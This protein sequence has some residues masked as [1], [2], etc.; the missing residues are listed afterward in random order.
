MALPEIPE[1]IQPYYE[2]LLE[3]TIYLNARCDALSMILLALAQKTGNDPHAF[4]RIIEQTSNQCYSERLL[5]LE[6]QAPDLAGRI[7][8]RQ[9]HG[10]T[11]DDDRSFLIFDPP[12]D[13]QEHGQ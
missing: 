3:R 1:N 6:K 5:E 2:D 8:R 9:T 13:S 4:A 12:K 7:D 11:L 10:E